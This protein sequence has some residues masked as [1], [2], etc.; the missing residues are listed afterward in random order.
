ME[1]EIVAAILYVTMTVVVDAVDAFCVSMTETFV[2]W[3]C[4]LLVVVSRVCVLTIGVCGQETISAE[5]KAG[6]V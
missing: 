6:S 1:N 2:R 5:G 3:L 4:S